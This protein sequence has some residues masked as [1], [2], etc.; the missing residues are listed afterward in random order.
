[1]RR[2]RKRAR[3]FDLDWGRS[4]RDQCQ[5][6]RVPFFFKQAPGN[7][8]HV[9]SC[10]RLDGRQWTECP[11]QAGNQPRPKGRSFRENDMKIV[12]IG[13]MEGRTDAVQLAFALTQ[14][15]HTVLSTWHRQDGPKYVEDQDVRKLC[16][17]EQL[18]AIG[19]S[20][21]VVCL[22]IR[23]VPRTTFAELGYA[24]GLKKD[25]V[26]LRGTE[27]EQRCNFDALPEINIVDTLP[28]WTDS[29]AAVLAEVTRLERLMGCPM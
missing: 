28:S 19:E 9:V 8:G 7:G 17:L 29:V 3:P 1:M 23:G 2:A 14:A 20:D 27:P 18:W 6:A 4:L 25:V 5:H 15:G 10:P 21:V 12:I 16:T 22:T 13:P 24:I 26:W 11:G